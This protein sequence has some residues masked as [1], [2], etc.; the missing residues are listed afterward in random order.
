MFRFVVLPGNWAGIPEVFVFLT[1]PG[2]TVGVRVVLDSKEI[3]NPKAKSRAQ[4]MNNL[5]TGAHDSHLGLIK[6][7]LKF[8]REDPH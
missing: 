4:W 8:V 5:A 3:N 1:Q 2:H 6:T 7:F